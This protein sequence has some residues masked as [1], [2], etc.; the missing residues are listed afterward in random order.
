[1]DAL[2]EELLRIRDQLTEGTISEDIAFSE[3]LRVC[4]L[5]GSLVRMGH[6]QE[7]ENILSTKT[8]KDAFDMIIEK[9]AC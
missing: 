8:G 6:K 5:S 1:M 7:L 3:S 4:R 2:K 9:F